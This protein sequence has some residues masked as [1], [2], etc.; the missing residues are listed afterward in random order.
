MSDDPLDWGARPA[1]EG[2]L[3]WGAKAVDAKAEPRT[4]T[5]RLTGATGERYQTWPERLVRSIGSSVISGATLPGDV[6]QGKAQ[7][8]SSGAVPGSVPFGD[9]QSSGERVADLATIT[10]PLS[11]ALRASVRPV[12]PEQTP[13]PTRG[14]LTQAA[15]QGYKE[16]RSAGGEFSPETTGALADHIVASMDEKGR[17]RHL[18]EPVHQTV[19]LLRKEGP[20]SSSELKGILE[21]LG[22][23]RVSPDKSTRQAANI[24]TAEIKGFLNRAEPEAASAL[25]TADANFAA[26]AR[27]KTIDQT[28][29]IAGLR[30]GRAGYGGNAVNNMR[31]LLSPIVESA[32]K[33]NAKGF[34]PEEIAAMQEIIS[35]NAAT[36][37]LRMAGQLSPAKGQIATGL[38]YVT[39]GISGGIGAASNKLAAI[40]TSKQIDRLNEL[41]RKRSPAY[42]AAVQKATDEFSAA[43][44]SFMTNPTQAGLLKAV[45]AA[46]A[47]SAGLTRDGIPIPSGELLRR[48]QGPVGASAD[49]DQQQ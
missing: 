3:A 22:G 29:E 13:V 36:N 21:G 46:R 24:A 48:L 16:F 12:P 45:I 39:G 18:A 4:I 47:L 25:N 14:D 15:N 9:P 17:F 27:A 1:E 38:A 43:G 49:E 7:L 32:I 40:L 20:T 10:T 19:D 42:E 34:S 26:A 37:G 35:G 6:Y 44:D 8:P 5:D 41:V 11:P 30:T 23:L 28:S 31:Q 33:G 2:P